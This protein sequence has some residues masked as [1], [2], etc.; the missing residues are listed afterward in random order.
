MLWSFCFVPLSRAQSC[1]N[2]TNR[3][4]QDR[5]Q[6]N[7]EEQVLDRCVTWLRAG[8]W[9]SCRWR[10]AVPPGD[11]TPDVDADRP[12]LHTDF[13]SAETVWDKWSDRNP[14]DLKFTEV[15]CDEKLQRS[16][17]GCGAPHVLASV[18]Q[19]VCVFMS[20]KLLISWWLKGPFM[21]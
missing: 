1:V 6:T 2:M 16:L 15:L 5:W 10:S 18:L 8:W 7:R 3:R 11:G 14:E 17:E 20:F 12:S 19:S 9:D 21:K 13:V 4:G